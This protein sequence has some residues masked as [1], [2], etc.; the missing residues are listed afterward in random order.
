[1]EAQSLERDGAPEIFTQEGPGL[2]AESSTPVRDDA[3]LA[4]YRRYRPE[5]FADVI[6]Q[7]HVTDPLKRA[8]TN[9]RVTHAYLFSGPRG[10]GKTSSARILARSL[11]CEKGPTPE[12]CGS[13]QSCKDLARSGPG[14]IDVLEI[15][16][17]S[18]GGVDD[19][20]ELRERAFFAPVRSQYRVYIVDEA[21]MVTTQGFNA[22]LTLV[23][24]PPPHVKF[25]FA[26]TEPDKVIGTIRSRTHHYPFR[27]I[28]PKTM[29]S[30][31]EKI[32]ETE[33]VGI[34]PRV[35]PM[36]VRAG[37]G[38]V[39]DALSVLDQLIGGAPAS[40]VEYDHAIG[41]LGY[42]PDSL[43][44]SVVDA[45]ASGD[46]TG[47]FSGIDKVIEAGQD[48]RRFAEDLLT[49]LRDLVIVAAVPDALTNGLLDLPTDQGERY[50]AQASTMGIGSL[51]RA[52]EVVAAGLVG[53]RGTTAPRLQVELMC[54]RILLPGADVGD[55]GI[56]ARLEKLEKS[57]SGSSAGTVAS[58][59][60]ATEEP[61]TEGPT[62]APMDP[63]TTTVTSI[64]TTPVKQAGETPPAKHDLEHQEAA[65]TVASPQKSSPGEPAET[66]A[67]EPP[68]TPPQVSEPFTGELTTDVIH[69]HWPQ[70]LTCVTSMR[71][72]IWTL[73]NQHVTDTELRGDVL[74]VTFSESGP[75]DH[76]NR[77]NGE[78]LLSQAIATTMGHTVAIRAR[79]GS[80]PIP[81]EGTAILSLAT[82]ASSSATTPAAP[83][84]PPPVATSSVAPPKGATLK[85]VQRTG[86]SSIRTEASSA[87]E[88]SPTPTEQPTSEDETSEFDDI[89]EN[90]EDEVSELVM[91]LF[92]AELVS[93][94][95]TK[96]SSRKKN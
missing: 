86:E 94:E 48:P 78:E 80:E 2:F 93:E 79:L 38:S 14:S 85:S 21:H 88:S 9:N 17:A 77:S 89:V 15:D 54:A 7:E 6:G 10:C 81:S 20:R 19:A 36:V 66:P 50:Q 64:E 52:A 57:L 74:W 12:P 23:E 56:H 4:L 37:A 73:L 71:R 25:I 82:P 26:T 62:A 72:F 43:M 34:D 16:A 18:H 76:F 84:P 87:A 39:R 40:G 29:T 70:I 45:I 65:Q 24:E 90:V 42:T 13:C 96:P 68:R 30:F 51:T 1:M 5:I 46:S 11:N 63:P 22:L 8:L 95:K 92:D 69:T 41:L 31:L 47:V 60:R 75:R 35:I 32:C 55:R 61:S 49:R 83:T 3:P 27:L 91:E 59:V 33:G 67:P 44:D 58:P 28:P 53:M